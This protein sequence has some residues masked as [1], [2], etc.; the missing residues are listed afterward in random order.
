M[1]LLKYSENSKKI[2]KHMSKK[3]KISNQRQVTSSQELKTNL[4][5]PLPEL[6]L[7]KSEEMTEA[8]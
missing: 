1:I 7:H 2:N 8:F 3:T 6:L 4:Y 5:Q